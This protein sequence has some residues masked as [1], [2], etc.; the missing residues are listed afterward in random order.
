L[1]WPAERRPDPE[2]LQ[3]FL[4]ASA[5]PVILVRKGEKRT[6]DVRPFVLRLAVADGNTLELELLSGQS[7][8]GVKPMELLGAILHLPAAEVHVARV[9]KEWCRES[10]L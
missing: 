8:A 2:L 7:Q 10:S 5:V 1:P 4:Q 3:N 6:L 9:L